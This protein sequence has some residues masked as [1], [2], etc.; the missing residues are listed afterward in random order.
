MANVSSLREFSDTLSSFGDL[1]RALPALLPEAFAI[2]PQANAVPEIFQPIDSSV[3]ARLLPF[4]QSALAYD[5]HFIEELFGD[6]NE[7]LT[8]CTQFRD[9]AQALEVATFTEV[10]DIQTK[11]EV[12]ELQKNIIAKNSSAQRLM[13]ANAVSLDPPSQGTGLIAN[14]SKLDSYW[15]DM[16]KMNN[17]H[18]N[19]LQTELNARIQRMRE[20]GNAG[21]YT[22]RFDELKANFLAS[23]EI[24]YQK[25]RSLEAGLKEI[26]KISRPLPPL[27]DVG[28]F[29]A[30][31]TW[32]TGAQDS[33]RIA[34]QE[35]RVVTI[36]FPFHKD[37]DDPVASNQTRF[38][39]ISE[40][41]SA[42]ATGNF[43]FKIARDSLEDALAPLTEFKLRGL[44]LW[45]SD[46]KAGVSTDAWTLQSLFR[47]SITL[48]SS[49][50][51]AFAPFNRVL[52]SPLPV[53]RHLSYLT[54]ENETAVWRGIYNRSPLGQWSALIDTKGLRNEDLKACATNLFLRMRLLGK[55]A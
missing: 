7:L 25:A 8:T 5:P 35:W 13:I 45:F 34:L 28:F 55:P 14:G 30:L 38:Y 42:K 36:I 52:Q 50:P 41:N 43:D 47:G 33:Y 1:A 53:V 12:L 37:I 19:L 15:N 32:V 44:D 20:P 31:V 29:S 40:Y 11:R 48:P 27:S 51:T 4:S 9:K 54:T 17:E 22:A 16:E 24:A 18:I 2:R 3:K 46:A 21:N 23:L 49:Q 6:L 39:R 10:L 26:F